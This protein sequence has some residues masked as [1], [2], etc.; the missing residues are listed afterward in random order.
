M[1]VMNKGSGSSTGVLKNLKKK[2]ASKISTAEH[3]RQMKLSLNDSSGQCLIACVAKPM[4]EA[5]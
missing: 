3:A 1:A 2:P 5:R 4:A